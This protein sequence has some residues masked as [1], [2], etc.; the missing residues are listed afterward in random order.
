MIPRRVWIELLDEA[1][2]DVCD[3]IVEMEDGALYTALF[4]TQAYLQRQMDLCYHVCKQLEDTPAVRFAMLETPHIFVEALERDMIEDVIDN[5]MA[6]D[7]FEGF[8]TRVTEE[9]EERTTNHGKRA[10][11]EVV[12]VVMS[13]V[14]AVSGD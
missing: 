4:A 1:E 9:G 6:M 7:T 3:V 12:A 14:L 11:S 5:M 13:E 2:N 10:T 8:F